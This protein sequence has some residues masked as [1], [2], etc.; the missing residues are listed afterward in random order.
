MK[1]PV[2]HQQAFLVNISYTIDQI[3]LKIGV[4]VNIDKGLI[5]LCGQGHWVKGQ[6]QIPYF[7][8][9]MFCL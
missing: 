1:L 3:E 7:Q 5:F 4:M 8:R 2:H 9:K 6:S